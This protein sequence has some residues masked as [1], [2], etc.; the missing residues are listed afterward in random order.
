MS[1]LFQR[2]GHAANLVNAH[3]L[4]LNCDE[5]VS[6]GNREFEF[7]GDR[8]RELHVVVL[9]GVGSETKASWLREIRVLDKA[10]H[11]EFGVNLVLVVEVL[12]HDGIGNDLEFGG[13]NVSLC[14]FGL[15]GLIGYGK[16]LDL[17]HDSL[18]LVDIPGGL[19]SA[20]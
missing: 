7:V 9:R 12:L 14:V 13:A 10:I 5:L 17:G 15:I 4:E 18:R 11:P 20:R 19:G 1:D 2:S 6:A 16:D 8:A 3:A